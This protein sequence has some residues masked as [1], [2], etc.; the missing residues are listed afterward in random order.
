M[1]TVRVKW[2]MDDVLNVS[3]EEWHERIIRAKRTKFLGKI[4][5]L[6]NIMDKYCDDITNRRMFVR[7]MY[8]KL[9]DIR[10]FVGADQGK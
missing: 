7:D 10:I 6:E 2:N 4:N 8:R 3:A 9:D 1:S 5:E